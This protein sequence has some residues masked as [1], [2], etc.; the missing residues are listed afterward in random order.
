MYCRF[1]HRCVYY[2]LVSSAATNGIMG[3]EAVLEEAELLCTVFSDTG[4]CVIIPPQRLLH[5]KF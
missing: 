3:F 4:T 1:R 5:I 2:F